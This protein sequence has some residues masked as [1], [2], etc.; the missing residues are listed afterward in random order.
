[1]FDI[2]LVRENPAAVKKNLEKRQ[3]KEMLKWL[4]DLTSKDLQWRKSKQEA[5]ALRQRRN[6]ISREIN[7]A[8]KQGRDVKKLLDE[9]KSLPE[10]ITDLEQQDKKLQEKID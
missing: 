9:A 6:E 10:K 3:Q 4:D 5:D 1:M 2:N 7:E 8:K